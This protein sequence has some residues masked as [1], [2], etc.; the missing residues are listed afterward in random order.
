MYSPKI[1]EDL[2]PHLYKLAKQENKPMT[3]VVDEIL[4]KGITKRVAAVHQLGNDIVSNE[5]KKT[6]D[7]GGS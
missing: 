6:A 4:R 2:I 3:T 5:V 1:K 7:D